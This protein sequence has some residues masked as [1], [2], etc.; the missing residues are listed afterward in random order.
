MSADLHTHSRASDGRTEP[1]ENA[2]LARAAGLSALALTDHDTF[3]GWE[4]CAEACARWGLRFV[5]GVELSAELDGLSVHVLGYWVDPTDEAL[6]AECDRL[7]TERDRRA[8]AMVGKLRALGVDVTLERVR[9]LAG[10][11]PVGRPHIAGAMVEA[12]AVP[13]LEAAFDGWIEDSGPA[14]EPKRALSPVDAVRLLRGAGGVA[15]LAHPGASGRTGLSLDLVDS[16]VA[17]GLAGIECDTPAHDPDVA[18]RWRTAALDRHLVG[19]GSSDFH[20]RD[21]GPRI[22]DHLTSNGA[23]D[24]LEAA[25]T[26]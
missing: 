22:G 20:G 5:P 17:A 23:L 2:A 4:A 19:T 8:E 18:D 15:V 1:G 12:G 11:A 14:Y 10:G 16:M 25:R 7:R 21:A 3:A 24:A 26:A 13:D 9:E 6:A